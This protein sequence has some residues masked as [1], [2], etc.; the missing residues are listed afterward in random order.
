VRARIADYANRD[1]A[2]G[3][4]TEHLLHDLLREAGEAD[5]S[6]CC[7]GVTLD[8]QKARRKVEKDA[9]A[10]LFSFRNGYVE[11]VECS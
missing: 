1:P 3:N 2:E 5:L 6:V 8:E 10:V 4:K 7:A 9:V 11:S